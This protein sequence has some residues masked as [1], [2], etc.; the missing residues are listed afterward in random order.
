MSEQAETRHIRRR[1]HAFHAGKIAARRV[2]ARGR[3]DHL[4]IVRRLEN[5]AFQRRAVNAHAERFAEDQDVTCLCAGVQQQLVRMH[6]AHCD[7]TVDR[8]RGI[9]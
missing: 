9:D 2:Q 8:F 5:S 4:G 7:K 3:G 6:Q 1:V